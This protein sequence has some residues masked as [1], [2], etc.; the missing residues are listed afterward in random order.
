LLL[1]VMTETVTLPTKPKRGMLP[2]LVVLFLI[3]YG[4]LAYLV[5]E[6]DR[7]IGSQR[8]LIQQLLS[9]S[10]ELTKMKGAAIQQGQTHAKPGAQPNAPSAQDN[11]AGKGKMQKRVVPMR[12]PTAASDTPDERRNLV[13]I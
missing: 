1:S 2:F 10:L 13:T 5:M 3:S 7:T 12:P 4:M 8:T 11:A 6:Q 9:D